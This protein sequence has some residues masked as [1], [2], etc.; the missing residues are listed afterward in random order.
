MS[1]NQSKVAETKPK[2]TNPE[3]KNEPGPPP[4]PETPQPPPDNIPPPLIDAEGV[5]KP[6]VDTGQDTKESLEH[7]DS[8]PK[9]SSNDTV[10]PGPVEVKDIPKQDSKPLSGVPHPVES[11]LSDIVEDVANKGEATPQESR[12]ET[13]Q[14]ET[15]NV[16][17]GIGEKPQGTE[18]K[19]EE[20]E[21]T[22]A[23]S[24]APEQ[25]STKPA[26]G[27]ATKFVET[28][29]QKPTTKSADTK[30]QEIAAKS[31][32][33]DTHEDSSKPERETQDLS[34]PTDM[35][36]QETIPQ[37]TQAISQKP[38]DTPA[39]LPI[40]ELESNP[41][42][43]ET[44]PTANPVQMDAKEPAEISQETIQQP[45]ELMQEPVEK[46]VEMIQEPVEKPV[47][48]IQEQIQKPVELDPEPV[49]S[50]QEPVKVAQE[51][52][53]KPVEMTPD[54]IQK[55]VET[56]QESVQEPVQKQVE[57][58][59]EP[60]EMAQE[61][62]EVTPDSVQKPIEMTEEIFQK[63]EEMK[64]EKPA[65][66]D[67][68]QEKTKP[69]ETMQPE[70]R[71]ELPPSL[72][73]AQNLNPPK[74]SIP[75]SVEAPSPAEDST[76]QS[77]E[78]VTTT[79]QTTAPVTSVESQT[80]VTETS[81]AVPSSLD[82]V[83]I[84]EDEEDKTQL[85]PAGGQVVSNELPAQECAVPPPQ[86][87]IPNQLTE[88]APTADSKEKLLSP[89][90]M[91]VDTLPPPDTESMDVGQIDPT[92]V[93][94]PSELID[95]IV[96]SD[97]PGSTLSYSTQSAEQMDV[98]VLNSE[99]SPERDPLSPQSSTTPPSKRSKVSLS[100]IVSPH[101][102]PKPTGS[103]SKLSADLELLE[104][105]INSC[106][107]LGGLT[108]QDQNVCFSYQHEGVCNSYTFICIEE[109]YPQ[110]TL[111]IT[112]KHGNVSYVHL[113]RR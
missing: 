7:A 55:P 2:A 63:T 58:V 23:V 17:R 79:P 92:S 107:K 110:I 16:Q 37:P 5:G 54:S 106:D 33:L 77:T 90:Q 72:V 11:I 84:V 101:S 30:T 35:E 52:V 68:A 86:L 95:T 100:D 67:E 44:E 78:P 53:Q 31:A 18:S 108:V 60:V 6:K 42:P 12:K 50:I 36:M 1:S 93:P 81:E 3:T 28:E 80:A 27:T 66:I 103:K 47:E 74:D 8:G 45:A 87:Q 51:P 88:L 40:Q 46:P 34:K 65:E 15:E 111:M 19:P 9:V 99:S 76:P 26:L 38:V 82:D 73:P 98:I 112:S 75:M 105:L 29:I 32:E 24:T 20:M 61:P 71:A 62:V 39:T 96:I 56:V 59:Q 48:M 21:A 85:M 13:A 43:M 69:I 113:Y 83:I 14:V 22:V 25:D 49:E 57:S 97:S 10:S 4:V 91:Q 102:P 94:L 104:V 70:K 64:L 109:D 89:E 41:T